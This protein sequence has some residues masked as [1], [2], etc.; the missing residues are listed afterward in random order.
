MR[1]ALA[2]DPRKPYRVCD[3]CYAKL[4]K[5]LEASI[6][7][8]KNTVPRLSGENKDRLDKADLRLS[9][10]VMPSN[11]DLIKQLDSKAAKQGK[12]ADAFS[13]VRS[14]QTP[15]FMQL[16]DVVLS[17][18]VDL[19]RAGPKPVVTS[20]G[21]SSRS[22]SPFSRRPSPPRSATPVPTTS[23][24]SFSKSI[25]DSL[26]KTNELLNHEVL[27]LRAQVL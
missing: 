26:K 4:N 20:S 23:G 19:Q 9:K 24:L 16:K 21:V 10:S 15:S 2:P 11:M 5:V 13:L 6:N 12:K 18:A 7:N 3:S 8:R 1:A 14:S 25:T 27:K 17:T 22:I